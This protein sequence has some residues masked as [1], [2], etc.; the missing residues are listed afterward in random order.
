MKYNVESQKELLLYLIEN[1]KIERKKAKAMLTNKSIYVNNKVITK[2]NY[3]LKNN[4]EIFINKNSDLKIIYEDNDILVVE[5]P[6][7]LLTISTKNEKEKTLYHLVSD[8]V[9]KNNKKNRIF[10]IHRLDKDTSGIVMFAKNEKIKNMYQDNWNEIVKKR[11]Y[12][13][14][15]DGIVKKSGVVESYL[16]EDKNYNVYSTKDKNGKFAKTEYKVIKSNEKYTLLDINILT[17]RKNQIRVHM[18]DINHPII[19]DKKY[20]NNNFNRLG[21]H[22]YELELI[23]PKNK[24][25]MNF[26][27][28]LP[29]E[30]KKFLNEL[31]K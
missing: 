24:K 17:G 9:K 31:K 16:K 21:L 22:A 26:K 5:K 13:A 8:Y 1:L 14:I 7:G 19:G 18:K 28:D 6:N 29:I 23:N 15:V 27:V 2:Y 25:I 30:L 20:G 3:L 11:K 10:V 12:Y 4:D